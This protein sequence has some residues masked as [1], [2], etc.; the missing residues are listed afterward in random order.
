[1]TYRLEH[2]SLGDVQVP[3]A[4]LYGAQTQRAINNF[5]IGGTPMPQGFIRA[6]ASI[7]KA[8]AKAN[9]QS[10]LLDRSRGQA[11]VAAAQKIEDGAFADQFPVD[12]YQTGS[13]T[14]SNMNMNEVLATLASAEIGTPTHPN[15]HVN[16][17]QS[18]NDVVPSALQLSVCIATVDTLFPALEH[19]QKVLRA[20]ATEYA[21]VI[22]TG[23]THLMDAMPI[24]LDQEVNAWAEQI[25]DARQGIEH[26]LQRLRR[27]PIG[28]TAVGTGINAP[29]DFGDAVA[30]H[31]S[32]ASGQTFTSQK[33]FR[34]L[35]SQDAAIAF[36]GQLN[37]LTTALMKI[38]NDLRWMNSG[39]LAGL[40]EIQLPALQPGSSIMPG[41]INPVIPEAVAMACA[42]VTGLHVSI[43]CAGQSGN[44]QLNVMLPLIANNL[45]QGVH[46]LA[47]G[48]QAL[49]DKAIAGMTINADHLQ[50]LL[51]KNP[52]LVTALNS[53]IGYEK[54]AMVAKT[55]LAEGRTVLEI[56]L[57]HTDL[58]REELEDLLDPRQ[59]TE[60]GIP[61]SRAD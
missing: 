25:A 40:G 26:S 7:K 39:P 51:A 27:L 31:L 38:S 9:M 47:N 59:L 18:S 48:A 37:V 24:R 23:R 33:G 36:S 11:I 50:K 54:G 4:A 5:D 19:L 6:L 13:G 46:L 28:G 52:M 34:N 29:K 56:A 10:T 20:R 15:D 55:A 44:F 42:H 41:K 53:R 49:A 14:S 30:T 12:V 21:D 1:M 2:D 22:K 32:E 45:L 57:E 16:M 61:D 35:G 43:T 58:S 60:R 17:C 8:A 3:R